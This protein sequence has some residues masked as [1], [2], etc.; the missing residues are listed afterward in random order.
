M[1]YP[2][3]LDH[4]PSPPRA[5]EDLRAVARG[6]GT[7]AGEVFFAPP[8]R[9]EHRCTCKCG[10]LYDRMD[11]PTPSC[12]DLYTKEC[13]LDGWKHA[14]ADCARRLTPKGDRLVP[15]GP[16]SSALK[17]GLDTTLE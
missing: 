2:T 10:N 9:W 17:N 4:D 11:V 3:F 12:E 7:N 15:S 5:R 14:L 8:L 16:G 6:D 13:V 1:K